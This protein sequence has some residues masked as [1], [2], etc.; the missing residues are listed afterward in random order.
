MKKLI[1]LA[2]CILLAFS[3]TSCGGKAD[4]E[5]PA[6]ELV[7]AYMQYIKDFDL[8]GIKNITA[9]SDFRF[10]DEKFYILPEEIMEKVKTWSHDIEWEIG[11]VSIDDLKATVNVKVKYADATAAMTAASEVYYSE[12]QRVIA[13]SGLSAMRTDDAKLKKEINAFLAKCINDAIETE[14]LGKT[15]K[16]IPVELVKYQGEWKIKNL[17]IDMFNVLTS[18]AF[19]LSQEEQ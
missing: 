5:G 13:A 16:T 9:S 12:V 19:I 7:T 4:E 1:C 15:E 2:L 3:L 11:D 10:V 8:E 6:K 17:S 14:G 18:N